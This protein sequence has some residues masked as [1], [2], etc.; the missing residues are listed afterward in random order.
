MRRVGGQ[1]E[2]FA[3]AEGRGGA[4]GAVDDFERHA[5]SVLVAAFGDGVDVVVCAG[6][7]PPTTWWG[8][9]AVGG[10]VGTRVLLFEDWGPCLEEEGGKDKGE[11][12][13]RSDHDFDAFV[14][15]AVV[16]DGWLQEMGN[17]FEPGLLV[18]ALRV[19]EGRAVANF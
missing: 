4:G 6:L 19:L 3:F 11:S 9:R 17:L 12:E 16:V 10:C 8:C 5:V 2:H 15:D 1:D 7:G 18:S 13:G 14:I